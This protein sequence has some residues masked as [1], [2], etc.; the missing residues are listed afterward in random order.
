MNGANG[1]ASLWSKTST[2]WRN[3]PVRKAFIAYTMCFD[4]RRNRPSVP[5]RGGDADEPTR[6]GM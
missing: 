4:R 5:Y 2:I 1:R 6:F 3:F